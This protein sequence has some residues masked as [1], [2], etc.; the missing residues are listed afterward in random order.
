MAIGLP[1]VAWNLHLN[2]HLFSGRFS[3]KPKFQ[4]VITCFGTA[5]AFSVDVLLNIDDPSFFIIILG[6]SE[7]RL[8]LNIWQNDYSK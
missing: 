6:L 5:W 8:D 2:T 3:I 4:F 1:D 7:H